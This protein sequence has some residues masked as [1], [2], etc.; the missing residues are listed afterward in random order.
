MSDSDDTLA[1]INNIYEN[2]KKISKH[3]KM[4][5]ESTHFLSKVI[6]PLEFESYYTYCKLRSFKK[7]YSETGIVDLEEVRNKDRPL[8]YTK[9]NKKNKEKKLKEDQDISTSTRR[10]TRLNNKTED[11]AADRNIHSIDFLMNESE[12]SN[13]DQVVMLMEDVVPKSRNPVRRSDVILPPKNRYIRER[14]PA[15]KPESSRLIKYSAFTNV[16]Q[17]KKFIKRCVNGEY[18]RTR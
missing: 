18:K 1:R 14:P 4:I 13:G 10:S 12:A 7:G 5:N 2:S 9:L 17:I 15:I 6:K 8:Y 16:P 11:I 3:K